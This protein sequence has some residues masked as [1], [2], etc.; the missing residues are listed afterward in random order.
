MKAF[1]G[2]DVVVARARG[3]ELVFTNHSSSGRK[4]HGI[5][6]QQVLMPPTKPKRGG[7]D[8][9]SPRA[10][11]DLKRHLPPLAPDQRGRSDVQNQ[12]ARR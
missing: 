4:R 2:S 1:R 6:P 10:G 9:C 3:D 11:G 8:I 5:A 12:K 7:Y